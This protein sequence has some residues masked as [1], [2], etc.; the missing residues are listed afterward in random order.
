MAKHPARQAHNPK[1]STAIRRSNKARRYIHDLLE[2]FHAGS[3]ING[4]D[5]VKSIGGKMWLWDYHED[6]GWEGWFAQYKEDMG[7]VIHEEE[8]KHYAIEHLHQWV[9]P[10]ANCA[11]PGCYG[12]GQVP[13]PAGTLEHGLEYIPCSSC[14]PYMKSWRAQRGRLYG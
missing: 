14:F 5:L 13:K 8:V 4:P 2:K 9:L 7:S 10:F 1:G 11:Y 12:S 3:L 6:T